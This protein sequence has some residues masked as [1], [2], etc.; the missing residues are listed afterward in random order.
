[1]PLLLDLTLGTSLVRATLLRR[2]SERNRSPFVGDVQLC[3]GR[4]AIAHLPSMEMGG[5]CVAGAELLLK[6]ATN[7]KGTPVGSE[8]VSPK[9]GT[10]KCE[11][12]AQ[13][14]RVDEG[15]G[16]VWCGANP[17]L[18]ERLAEEM[19]GGKHLDT[20][21]SAPVL[22]YKREVKN[23]AGTGSRADF[24]LLHTSSDNAKAEDGAAHFSVLEVKTVVDTSPIN[25]GA[26]PQELRA[27]FPWGRSKQKGPDGERVVSARAIKHVDELAALA[28]GD[29]VAWQEDAEE[30]GAPPTPPGG[31]RSKGSEED[32][33]LPRTGARM[34]AVLLFVVTRGDAG[35]FSPNAEACPSFARHLA[36]AKASGVDVQAHQVVWGE[37]EDVGRAFYGGPVPVLLGEY[38]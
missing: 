10:P 15:A 4:V 18:G 5:K 17:S 1:M 12:I 2:P 16:E 11:F 22:S 20:Y 19:I 21:L 3:D 38:K 23:I 30:D 27:T 28:R 32:A 34:G 8:A 25:A 33:S 36:R 6:V 26:T 31:G 13:L 37:G 9:Y 24:V 29:R 35:A 7:Q 14:L